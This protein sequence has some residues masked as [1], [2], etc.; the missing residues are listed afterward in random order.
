M[1][2]VVRLQPCA[3]SLTAAPPLLLC[4]GLREGSW[5]GN[6]SNKGQD[7]SCNKGW[8]WSLAVPIILIVGV[9]REAAEKRLW[10]KNAT[11]P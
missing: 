4:A 5:G 9:S 3:F 10:Y 7:G 2:G 11:L 6:R 1:L 8:F